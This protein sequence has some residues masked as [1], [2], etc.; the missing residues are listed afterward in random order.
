[1]LLVLDTGCSYPVLRITKSSPYND[2][3]LLEFHHLL[4][5]QYKGMKEN[6]QKYKY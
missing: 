4:R 1:M 6:D 5:D 3:F 2:Q